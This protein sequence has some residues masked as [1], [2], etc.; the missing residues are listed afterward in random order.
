MGG[1]LPKAET[2]SES[3]S[4]TYNDIHRFS[5]TQQLPHITILNLLSQYDSHSWVRQEQILNYV[6]ERTGNSRG[7]GMEPLEFLFRHDY[8]EQH[9]GRGPLFRI[10]AKGREAFKRICS[11]IRNVSTDDEIERHIVDEILAR[12]F[13]P[14]SPS[15]AEKV[16]EEVRQ[17]AARRYKRRGRP[18]KARREVSESGAAE[19]AS[20][21]DAGP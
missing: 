2:L 19:D 12:V 17:E 9:H 10:T 8:I 11:D 20:E 3:I 4:Q 16:I 1:E 15:G 14:A 21:G 18:R 5:I 7:C 6:V 13:P